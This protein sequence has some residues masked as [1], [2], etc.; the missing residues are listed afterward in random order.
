[1]SVVIRAALIA[2]I[3]ALAPIGAHAATYAL[4]CGPSSCTASDGSTQPA[5]TALATIIWDGKT[6]YTPPAGE[7][8]VPYTGQPLY[9]AA[10]PHPTTI[11]SL[12]FFNRFTAA[13][14]AAV[15]QAA[16]AAPATLGVGLTH[17]LVAGTVNLAGCPSACQD[18]T[19]KAWMDG[20]VTAGAI[21]SARESAILTP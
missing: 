8:A 1:M 19:L 12:A 2:P 4:V 21:T 11:T 20:L 10:V 5:G 9:Q 7:Q 15:Q 13:E 14:Q 6:P 18:T 16:A 3:L 17:G